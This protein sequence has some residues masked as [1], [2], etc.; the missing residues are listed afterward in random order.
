MFQAFLSWPR[1]LLERWLFQLRGVEPGEVFLHR[2]RVFVLPSRAGLGFMLLLI[3]LFIASIN[4]NLSLGFALTFLLAACGVVD[5]HLSFRNLAHLYL[6]PGRTS[7]VFAGEVAQF[8][9]Q[10]HNRSRLNRY[11]LWL[12]FINRPG[13]QRDQT[14]TE[15]IAHVTDLT[16]HSS[17]TISLLV[18]TTTRGWL[19]APRVQLITRFPLGLVR[20]WSYWQ[21]DLRTLVYPTPELNAPPLP[22]ANLSNTTG[23]GNAGQDDFSGVRAYRPGDAPKR[24]AWRQMAKLDPAYGGVLLTKQFDG[25]AQ[26][27]LIL[28]F[29]SL[30]SNMN[31][32]QKLSRLTR[33]ILEADALEQPYAFQLGDTVYS[34]SSGSAHRRACLQA[35][36][37]F[38]TQT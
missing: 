14:P 34:A 38:P 33:W 4:Y 37:L 27:K 22:S 13:Q 9:L 20:A 17:Q 15:H 28:D 16:A 1:R 30:P 2:R 12:R 35:L 6:A 26:S 23:T 10:L 31:T 24:L 18:L 25:G 29:S 5:I 21:P 3:I 8:E 36:A 32:E 7:P 19:L 11:A